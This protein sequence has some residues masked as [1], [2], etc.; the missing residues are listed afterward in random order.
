MLLEILKEI[1]ESK[2]YSPAKLA[3]KYDRDIQMIEEYYRKLIELGYIVESTM[4]NCDPDACKSCK[5]FCNISSL[6]I[7][8]IKITDKGL[9]LLDNTNV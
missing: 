9:R 2:M 4:G 8:E 7:K 6:V 5:N 3:Q 1:Y